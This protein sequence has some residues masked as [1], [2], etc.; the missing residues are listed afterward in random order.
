M[1]L[2]VGMVLIKVARDGLFGEMIGDYANNIT[3]YDVI[4]GIKF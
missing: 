3:N 1:G 2:A 4:E